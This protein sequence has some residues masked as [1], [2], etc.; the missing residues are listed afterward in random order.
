MQMRLNPSHELLA[1]A[2]DKQPPIR[3]V[4]ITSQQT[5]IHKRFSFQAVI[6]DG[7]GALPLSPLMIKVFIF[8]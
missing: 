7:R 6:V 3:F 4:H 2:S 1:F 8:L 5:K